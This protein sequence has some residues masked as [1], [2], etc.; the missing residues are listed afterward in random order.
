MQ[1]K[2]IFSLPLTYAG[3]RKSTSASTAT[4]Q[5]RNFTKTRTT[6]LRPRSDSFWTLPLLE[7]GQETEA[8]L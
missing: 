4:S 2:Y 8:D 7:P 5:S 1:Y 3:I 6:Y